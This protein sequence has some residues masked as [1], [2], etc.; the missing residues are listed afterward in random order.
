MNLIPT[1]LIAWRDF[2]GIQ[3]AIARHDKTELAKQITLAA[4]LALALLGRTKYAQLTDWL[5]ANTLV[6]L[7]VLAAAA[8]SKFGHWTTGGALASV[9]ADA[10]S[11][12]VPSAAP[13]RDAGPSPIVGGEPA[14]T[15]MQPA[16]DALSHQDSESM[17]GGG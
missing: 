15:G 16:P 12:K 2:G 5:D 7:G 3:R 4:T 9:A 10:A 6:A 11:A 14:Q 8:I 1:A 13:I 17:R